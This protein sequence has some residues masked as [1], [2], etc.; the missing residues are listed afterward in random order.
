M[1]VIY[2]SLLTQLY[3]LTIKNTY[4]QLQYLSSSATSYLSQF[5]VL[6]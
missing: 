6:F 5:E 3:I 2:V 1:I 4:C